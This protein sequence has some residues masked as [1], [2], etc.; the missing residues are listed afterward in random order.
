VEGLVTHNTVVLM[1]NKAFG[2][3]PTLPFSYTVPGIVPKTHILVNMSQTVD[4]SAVVNASSIT[5]TVSSG[6]TYTPNDQGI[7]SFDM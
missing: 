7:V 5:Y 2:Q 3:M 4:V 1:S 6:A